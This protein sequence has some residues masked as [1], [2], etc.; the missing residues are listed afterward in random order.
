MKFAYSSVEYK[1]CDKRNSV[2]AN[3]FLDNTLSW[4]LVRLATGVEIMSVL[5]VGLMNE[6]DRKFLKLSTM[7]IIK[8]SICS[9]ASV[10][11][12]FHFCRPLHSALLSTL[13]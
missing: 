8:A 3:K 12:Q 5:S 4:N 7:C 9:Q 10:N 1:V 6:F 13:S 2:N 11:M